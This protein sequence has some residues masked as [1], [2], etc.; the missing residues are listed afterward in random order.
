MIRQCKVM[1]TIALHHDM[2]LMI[3]LSGFGLLND[4]PVIHFDPCRIIR[5][6]MA[7]DVCTTNGGGNNKTI[8]GP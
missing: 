1:V 3:V 2:P 6:E 4:S 7:L 8:N 5:I